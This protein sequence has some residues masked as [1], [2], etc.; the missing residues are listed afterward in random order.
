MGSE[1]K[2]SHPAS[3]CEKAGLW[4][5]ALMVVCLIGSKHACPSHLL[6][7]AVQ[8]LAGGLLAAAFSCDWLKLEC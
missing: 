2:P 6:P 8:I 3:P 1:G 4:W 5:V 7:R